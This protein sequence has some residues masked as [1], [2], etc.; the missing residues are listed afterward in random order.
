L[1]GRRFLG[2]E[3]GGRR[4]RSAHCC[5]GRFF[6]VVFFKNTNHDTTPGCAK[7]GYFFQK[8][9]NRTTHRATLRRVVFFQKKPTTTPR[10]ATL[11]WVIFFKKSQPRHHVEPRYVGLFFSKKANHT[12]RRAALRRVIF[13]KKANYTTSS[14]PSTLKKTFHPQKPSVRIFLYEK[15]HGY[16]LF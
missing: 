11:R 7:S 8:K 4:V 16:G 1:N 10:R 14:K 3:G 15:S 5:S 12:T 2:V 13:F 6:G 9:A